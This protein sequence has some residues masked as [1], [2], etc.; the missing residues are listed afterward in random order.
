M[1]DLQQVT[2][3]LK[4]VIRITK[5][6]MEHE[7]TEPELRIFFEKWIVEEETSIDFWPY[8]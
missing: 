6:W 8:N 3:G 7:K 2:Y 5:V 4:Y 1:A